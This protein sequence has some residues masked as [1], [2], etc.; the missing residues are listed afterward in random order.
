MIFDASLTKLGF[1]QTVEARNSIADLNI[2]RVITS[3][4]TRVIQTA[5]TVFDAIAPIEVRHGHHELLKFSGDVD[6]PPDALSTDFPKLSFE[7]LP[8]RWWH[9]GEH[10]ETEVTVEPMHVFQTRVTADKDETAAAALALLAC[11]A[12]RLERGDFVN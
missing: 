10:S 5:Q 4:L 2:T 8:L 9:G 6:R 1:A 7:Y 12:H 3:P 11:V